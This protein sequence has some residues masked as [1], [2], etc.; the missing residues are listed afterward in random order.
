MVRC[1]LSDLGVNILPKY[2]VQNIVNTDVFLKLQIFYLFDIWGPQGRPGHLGGFLGAWGRI[3]VV[4]QGAGNIL[5]YC[6]P[7]WLAVGG[8]QNLGHEQMW[9]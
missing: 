3:F 9:W 6:Y 4:R 2:D 7:G 5:Q 1:F 8:S